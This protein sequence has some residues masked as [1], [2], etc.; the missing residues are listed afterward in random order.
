MWGFGTGPICQNHTTI[1]PL[2]C[3]SIVNVASPAATS[4]VV[5]ELAPAENMLID[6]VQ[7][8]RNWGDGQGTAGRRRAHKHYKLEC[9]D[10]LV[11]QD[12]VEVEEAE[13]R[14]S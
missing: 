9:F 1:F 13:K 7:W 12:E 2:V 3:S 5:V 14:N 4:C 8:R 10:K 11:D 6:C